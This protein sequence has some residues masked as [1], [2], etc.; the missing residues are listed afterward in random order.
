MRAS[1]A[2]GKPRARWPDYAAIWR[3]HFYAGLFC[4]PF[5]CWLAITGSIYIFRPDIEAWLDRPYESLHLAGLAAAPSAEA[6]AAIA[7]IPGSAFTL[8]QP[9]ATPTGAGQVVVTKGAIPYRVYIN[10]GTLKPMKV[11]RN[12]RRPMDIVAHLHGQLLLGNR[13]SMIVE[14]AACWAIVMIL[15][16]LYLWW[17]RGQRGLG[18]VLYP[19]LRRRG[20]LFWRDLHGVTGFWVSLIALFLLLSGLPWSSNWGNYLSWTRNL[21][22][23]TAGAP[24]WPVGTTNQPAA[25]RNLG[26]KTPAPPQGGMPGMTTAEMAAMVQVAAPDGLPDDQPRVD[27]HVLD[28]VV[29]LASR[30][31]VPQPVWITPPPAGF[32]DWTIASQIQD[33]PLRVTYTIDPATGAVTGERTFAQENIVDKVVNV[34]IATHEGHLFGRLNQA[35]LVLTAISLLTVSISAVVM[36]WRRRPSGMLGAPAPGARPR[37]SLWLTASIILLA[38]LLPLFGVSLIIV[39]ILDRVVLPR[40]PA[41]R[42]W[43]GRQPR[44]A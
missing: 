41:W 6:R 22:S 12:D 5:I 42:L 20:R 10:P 33:R 3:W 7:A 2:E 37:F 17:P 27:L 31:H 38:V 29:P 44:K 32:R 15:T 19:R 18:G 23:V 35:V 1:G 43:L 8:Y 40:L 16:G 14:L 34:V 26:G 39:L 30:L 21:W 11:Q 25:K 4:I 9:P 36:W 13:G 28:T 24:D